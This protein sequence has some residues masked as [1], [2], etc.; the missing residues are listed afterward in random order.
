MD[1]VGN[2]GGG[3]LKASDGICVF[4]KGGADEGW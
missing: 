4:V 1:D 3:G 2:G